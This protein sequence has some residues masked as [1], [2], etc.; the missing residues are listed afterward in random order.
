MSRYF[1]EK[2]NGLTP[3]VPGEQPRERTYIKLNTNELPFPPS[4]LAQQ[5]ARKQAGDL[6]LYPDPDCLLLRQTAAE[7]YGIG[8]DQIMF[9]NGS[10]EALNFAFMAYC[11]EDTPIAFPDVT[12]SF[13]K[14]LC[15]LNRITC[16]EIPVREDLSIDPEDYFGLKK[17]II[18]ANPN[19]PTGICLKKEVIEKIVA[20]NPDNVVIIDEAYVDFGGASCIDLI[21][22]YDNLL[23]IRTLSKSSALAGGRLGIAIGNEKLI[24]DLNV[25]RNSLNPYTINRMTMMA[26]VGVYSD[27]SY[28]ESCVE[29]IKAIRQAASERLT[30][31][32]FEVIPSSANFLF[33]RNPKYDGNRLYQDLKEQ[34]ILVRH[35]DTQRL[36]DYV[37][38][39][40]GNEDDMQTLTDTIGKLLEV[41]NEKS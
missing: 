3:Y 13:Y 12:Y 10:D 7:F 26:A 2:Y 23:I 8:K 9:T 18:I 38:I 35:F 20:S 6:S 4:P 39:S 14:V 11:D 27:R 41:K 36:K 22:T 40:I 24:A 32:G 5:L 37:R 17:T 19:A 30:E 25:L 28:L 33:A 1:S 21:D 34:G 16:E 29:R 31:L 15:A